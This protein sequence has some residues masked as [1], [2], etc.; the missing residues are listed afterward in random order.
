VRKRLSSKKITKGF[1]FEFDENGIGEDKAKELLGWQEVKNGDNFDLKDRKGNKVILRNNAKNRPIYKSNYET[2]TNEMLN[3]RWVF[4]GEPIIVGKSG[5]ILN[6]QH[7]LIAIIF[8]CQDHER[9]VSE[10]KESILSF[11]GKFHKVIIRGISE[12]NNVVDT[13]D[14]CKLRSFSDVVF[15]SKKF[16]SYKTADRKRVSRVIEFCVKFMWS[17]MGYSIDEFKGVKKTNCAMSEFLES[18]PSIENYAKIVYEMEEG[19]E[20]K[21]SY[22]APL[23][24]LSGCMYLMASSGTAFEDYHGDE[25]SI[26]LSLEKESISFMEKISNSKELIELRKYLVRMLESGD[27]SLPSRIAVVSNAWGLWVEGEKITEDNISLKFEKD[28]LGIPRLFGN[29]SFGGID[30]GNVQG[31][32]LPSVEDIEDIKRQIRKEKGH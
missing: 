30:K 7:T 3:G 13:M 14:T 29:Y 15:R 4:N 2:L 11:S 21:L 22:L 19:K 20:K 16:R 10:G 6:G 23:G 8:A 9:Y 1:E 28:D 17:R 31:I 24:T 18:H 27:S 26:D 12:E 5:S 32:H 25:K